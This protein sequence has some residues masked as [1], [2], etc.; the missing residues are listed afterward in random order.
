MNKIIILIGLCILLVGC[1][2]NNINEID[3]GTI[4]IESFTKDYIGKWYFCFY[5]EYKD[6]EV[7]LPYTETVYED[8]LV[9]DNITAFGVC[10]INGT[11]LSE[12]EFNPIN[13]IEEKNY[14]IEDS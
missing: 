6:S 2:N 11:C 9:P 13:K 12:I 14:Y 4:K 3:F 7:C 10:H 5:S 1:N 8:Y